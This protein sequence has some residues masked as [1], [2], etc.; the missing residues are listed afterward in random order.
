MCAMKMLLL[1]LLLL[2]LLRLLLHTM[3][4]SFPST[5][6]FARKRP[7]GEREAAM[8]MSHKMEC[9]L[10]EDECQCST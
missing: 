4:M 10:L 5:P 3:L 6:C 7:R 2:L 9:S 8:G 1:L